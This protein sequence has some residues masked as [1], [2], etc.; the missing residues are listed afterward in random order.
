MLTEELEAEVD[1]EIPKTW[2]RRT[3]VVQA[4]SE[5]DMDSLPEI[6]TRLV[7]GEEC[8]RS[9]TT[10]SPQ[11]RPAPSSTQLGKRDTPP[12]TRHRIVATPAIGRPIWEYGN[13]TELLNGFLCVL[14]GKYR[15]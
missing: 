7:L 4:A 3:L 9:L 14:E 2:R 15:R 6:R 10:I 12:S 13:E 5:G 8:S 11:P 1:R